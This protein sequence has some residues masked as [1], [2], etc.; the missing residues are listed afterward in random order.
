MKLAKTRISTIIFPSRAERGSQVNKGL[1]WRASLQS[2]RLD[3]QSCRRALFITILVRFLTKGLVTRRIRLRRGAP[4]C[5]SIL[6]DRELRLLNLAN[7][8]QRRV[9]I[10][11][12]SCRAASSPPNLSL[13]FIT[14]FFLPVHLSCRIWTSSS[15]PND[16]SRRS[17]MD[18]IHHSSLMEH[19]RVDIWRLLAARRMTLRISLAITTAAAR[20][21]SRAARIISILPIL[22]A[23]RGR[24]HSEPR[25]APRA[26]RFRAFTIPMADLTRRSR[27]KRRF[28]EFVLNSRNCRASRRRASRWRGS[29]RCAACHCIGRSRS[30]SPSPPT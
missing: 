13:V 24:A 25:G 14:F 3:A 22:E 12:R 27:L 1:S 20:T 23:S 7:L 30:S 15:P 11:S 4:R 18:R 2:W 16:V 9:L 17:C 19:M 21:A 5:D 10:T 28:G 26:S 8:T 6:P 29:S